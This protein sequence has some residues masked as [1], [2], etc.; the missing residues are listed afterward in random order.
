MSCT[1]APA[2]LLGTFTLSWKWVWTMMGRL[3]CGTFALIVSPMQREIEQKHA[4][5]GL[6]SFLQKDRVAHVQQD[7]R[8]ISPARLDNAN[9]RILR[10]RQSLSKTDKLCLTMVHK[11]CLQL[12]VTVC[13]FQS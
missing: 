12:S 1:V 2:P 10:Y 13:N 11:L 7:L 8:K 6:A 9:S 5:W 3:M 4:K